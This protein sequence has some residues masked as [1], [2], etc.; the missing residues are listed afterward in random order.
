MADRN[1]MSLTQARERWEG[2]AGGLLEELCEI[3]GIDMKPEALGKELQKYREP[4]YN[5]DHIFFQWRKS[6]GR[7]VLPHGVLAGQQIQCCTG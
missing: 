4:L 5:Q 1:M 7:R 3:Q 6:N 2:S